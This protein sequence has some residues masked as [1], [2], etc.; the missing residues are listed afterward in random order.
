MDAVV[1]LLDREHEARIEAL[2]D[3]LAREFGVDA[4]LSRV[5]IPHFS[6][7]VAEKYDEPKLEAALR[8]FA[9]VHRPFTVRCAG[10][11]I[12]TGPNPVLYIPIVRNGD[13]SQV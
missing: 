4:L 9:H 11:G 13:L 10:L 1:S 2:W 8:T 5:A 3:E 6:Y 12:F 7:H